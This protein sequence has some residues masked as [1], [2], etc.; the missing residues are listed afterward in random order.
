MIAFGFI[1]NYVIHRHCLGWWMRYN[2]I[3]AA[4]LDAGTMFSMA[5]I[6]FT[7]TL[8]KMGGIELNWWGNM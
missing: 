1:F 4:A 3:L 2:Y 7:L 5:I 6:F 8:P